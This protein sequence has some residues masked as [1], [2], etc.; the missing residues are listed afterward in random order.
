MAKTI[1]PS[2]P[3]LFLDRDGV[4]NVD[5]GYVHRIADFEWTA[6]AQNAV[7]YANE[8]N[9]LVIV[10]T[11]QSGVAR[12]YYTEDDVHALHQWMSIELAAA[13]A[14]IDAFYHSPYHPEGE[15]A[16]YR[17]HSN[18]RKPEPGMILQAFADWDIDIPKSFLIGD[19]EHD[20]LAAERAG[21]RGHLFDGSDLLDLVRKCIEANDELSST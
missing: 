21:I 6:T 20:V 3:A 17:R 18:L 10:V 13:G 8:Q 2:R 15:I 16:R 11:N 12:G 7:K 1:S 5:K 19:K 9:H 4:L 14:K